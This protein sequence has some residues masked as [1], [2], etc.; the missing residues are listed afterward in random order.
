MHADL[1]RSLADSQ[2]L[3]GRRGAMRMF[4]ATAALAGLGAAPARANENLTRTSGFGWNE[5]A[6]NLRMLSRMWGTIEEGET[7]ILYVWGPAFGMTDIETF[8]P[9]FRLESVAVVKT[10]AQPNGAFRYLANQIILF[11]DWRTGEVLERWTNPFTDEV[12][13]VFHYRDGPLDYVLDPAKM[14]ERYDIKT[15]DDELKRKLVLD[16]YFRGDMAYG[17]AIVKTRLK[18]KLDPKQWPRESVGEWWETFESYRW[19][20]KIA[21]IED[22]SLASIPSFTGDFQT[23]KPWEPWMLMDGRKGKI[24]SQRTAFK[25]AG[26]DSVPRPVMAYAEK[27]LPEF[28]TPPTK[29][30][31]AYKL[32]D[33]HFKEQRTPM[34][35]LR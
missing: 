20:A 15:K 12:C 35:V 9:L 19:Q 7:A 31:H 27:H 5:P 21:E 34:P 11:T 17:D 1:R 8:Q 26:F 32:N 24:F 4:G 18:N 13:E 14:P 25:I 2:G 22:R 16:W 30:D 10:Y 33:A 6:E 28:L 23:F 3:V 29:F